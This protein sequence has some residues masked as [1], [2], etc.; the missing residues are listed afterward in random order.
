MSLKNSLMKS[1][2]VLV[3][4]AVGGNAF[5]QSASSDKGNAFFLNL[6]GNFGYATCVDRSIIPFAFG[7]ATKGLDAGFTDEWKRCHIQFDF[8]WM[9]S[10]FQN[11]SGNMNYFSPK[12]EFLYSCLKPSSSRWHFWSGASM[13]GV[14][15]FK[16]IPR[17]QNAQ[18]TFS[19]FGNFAA[20]ELVQCDFAYDKKDKS[21]PWMTAFFK[22]SLP[23][24]TV[25]SRPGFAYV[26]H[27]TNETGPIRSL[28]IS[29]ETSFKMFPG[30]TTDL[31]FTV[32]LRNGN[33][34]SFGYCMDFLS[35]GKKGAYRYD[36]SYNIVYLQFMF[37]I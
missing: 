5:A 9:Q 37:K 7:G 27:H 26:Q 28:M 14:V 1:M 33:R 8:G 18:S 10:T 13:R 6:R 22:F 31:G 34:F 32:N 11:P 23:L 30:F 36:N 24:F 21:R 29:N 2:V 17:L 35:T 19:V 15:D 12:L 3:L 4:L 20:E 16:H 25:A